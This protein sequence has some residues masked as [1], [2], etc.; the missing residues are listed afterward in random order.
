MISPR[1]HFWVVVIVDV[2]V[3]ARRAFAI[4]CAWWRRRGCRKEDSDIP[5]Q[6]ASGHAQFPFASSAQPRANEDDT[7][8]RTAG[9]DEELRISEPV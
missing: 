5:E 2:V 6:T 1:S 9:K 7:E 4:H 3:T 8:E